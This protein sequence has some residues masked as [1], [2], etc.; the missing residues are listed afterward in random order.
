M[1]EL[2]PMKV[3]EDTGRIS[4]R[5][6]SV[7]MGEDGIVRVE[8]GPS[9]EHTV[10]DGRQVVEAHDLLAEQAGLTK[11]PVLADLRKAKVG[12]DA[13][14]RAYYVTDEAA[15]HKSAM[16]MLTSSVVQKMLGNFF[17]RVNRPPYPTQMFTDEHEAL[18]WLEEFVA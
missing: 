11:V 12:A 14:A 6:G 1:G 8:F 5:I 10:D 13:Q 2:H 3:S 4:I 15:E 16:A 18:S 7:W 17:F 9:P